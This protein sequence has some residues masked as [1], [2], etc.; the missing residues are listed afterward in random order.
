MHGF[1]LSWEL[2]LGFYDKVAVQKKRLKHM[3]LMAK[4][5]S[6]SDKHVCKRLWRAAVA[7]IAD[8]YFTICEIYPAAVHLVFRI[9]LL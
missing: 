7:G 3:P 6:A 9:L 8:V 4:A 2:F 5:A 1:L